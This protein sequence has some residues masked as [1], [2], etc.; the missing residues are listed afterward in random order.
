[1]HPKLKQRRQQ[2]LNDDRLP[3]NVTRNIVLTLPAPVFI[4][5][6]NLLVLTD[7]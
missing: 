3:V 1:L 7:L 2:Q 4:F 6:Q 5:Q